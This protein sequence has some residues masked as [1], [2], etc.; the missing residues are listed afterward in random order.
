MAW[1]GGEQE[2]EEGVRWDWARFSSV[3]LNYCFFGLAS[4]LWKSLG[5]RE[6][7]HMERFYPEVQTTRIYILF[8]IEK[9]LP[10]HIK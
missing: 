2:K 9:V 1:E 10:F 4:K 6:I 7:F 5:G 3:S 8:F